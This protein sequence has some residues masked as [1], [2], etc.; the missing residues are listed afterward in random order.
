MSAKAPLCVWCT[1]V[2]TDVSGTQTYDAAIPTT[3]KHTKSLD[4]EGMTEKWTDHKEL[5]LDLER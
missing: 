4:T 2:S 1:T 5:E 3:A